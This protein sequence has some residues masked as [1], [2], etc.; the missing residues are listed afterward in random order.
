MRKQDPNYEKVIKMR[1][2]NGE[3]TYKWNPEEDVP[4][5]KITKSSLGS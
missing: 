3:F 4:I 5:L 2:E 1:K